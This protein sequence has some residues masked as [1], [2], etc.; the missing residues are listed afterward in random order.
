MWW[1]DEALG[2]VP[3]EENFLR[4]VRVVRSALRRADF[5]RAMRN[6]AKL[7][8]HYAAKS[9]RHL[10]VCAELA[11][12]GNVLDGNWDDDGLEEMWHA[13]AVSLREEEM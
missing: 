13:A 8:S 7:F 3:F 5:D 9:D 6:L 2:E 12:V 1:F 11:L 4:G 10:Q